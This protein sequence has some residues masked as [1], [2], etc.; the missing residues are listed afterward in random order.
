MAKPTK[1]SAAKVINA[2]TG[3]RGIKKIICSRLGISRPTLDSYLK[4]WKR[5]KEAF[6]VEKE[7][8]LDE[9]EYVVVDAVVARR[10]LKT[11]KWVLGTKGA[12]RGYV[13]PS[14][15]SPRQPEEESI[16]EVRWVDHGPVLPVEDEGAL[17]LEDVL[18]E[19][20]ARPQ[21]VGLHREEN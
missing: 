11:S 10:C 15:S 17:S 18:L 5:A 16:E 12:S 4:R 20:D 14:S 13:K 9:A 21:D 1:H 2:I 8:F 19:L 6:E 7:D 3:S